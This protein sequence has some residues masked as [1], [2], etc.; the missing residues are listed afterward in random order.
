[1][2]KYY[3]SRAAPLQR[4]KQEYGVDDPPQEVWEEVREV[5][6]DGT[7]NEILALATKYPDMNRQVYWA[8][9][10]KAEASGD[11]AKAR[12]L[13]TEFPDEEQRRE[14]LAQIDRD[15]MSKTVSAEK[16]A[17]IQQQ[18]EPDA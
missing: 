3:A 13:A 1:M 11:V 15:Q 16:L 4:W 2:E 10:R 9:V 5:I 7:V 17:G 18:L 14:M 6:R 12:Q 8:A